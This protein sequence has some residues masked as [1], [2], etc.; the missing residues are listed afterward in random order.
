MDQRLQKIVRQSLPA[1]LASAIVDSSDPYSAV[2]TAW[3]R[4]QDRRVRRV[5][6][7]QLLRRDTRYGLALYLARDMDERDAT[8]YLADADRFPD[9]EGRALLMRSYAGEIEDP[10]DRTAFILAIPDWY[11]RTTAMLDN[12]LLFDNTDLLQRPPP[13]IP[14]ARRQEVLNRLL[15]FFPVEHRHTILQMIDDPVDRVRLAL[16][17]AP[18]IFSVD[19]VCGLA[20]AVQGKRRVSI[21]DHMLTAF[22]AEHRHTILQ[23]IDDPVDRAWLAL[24][25]CPSVFSIDD[26]CALTARIADDRVIRQRLFEGMDA[27]ALR[28][29]LARERATVSKERS[30]Q[31]DRLIFLM[32]IPPPSRRWMWTTTGTSSQEQRRSLTPRVFKR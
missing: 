15:D 27:T 6:A 28:L 23:T 22:P 25:H 17:H 29:R 14:R 11:H 4:I 24:A 5:L 32:G 8:A 16:N 3:D 19:E 30:G 10:L 13:T 18:G 7:E 31:L 21:V 20:N 26:V 9:S 12:P 2:I 1:G